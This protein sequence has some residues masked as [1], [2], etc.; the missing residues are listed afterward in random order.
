MLTL[1]VV[2][3]LKLFHEGVQF[4]S[5]VHFESKLIQNRKLVSLSV[6]NKKFSFNHHKI[7]FDYQTYIHNVDIY[8]YK[9]PL[10]FKQ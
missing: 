9:V 2:S 5:T 7:F 1:G 4:F 6:L 3:M 10:T 8:N